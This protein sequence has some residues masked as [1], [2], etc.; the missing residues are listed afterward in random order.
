MKSADNYK[1]LL[2]DSL[3][4]LITILFSI[5][6]TSKASAYFFDAKEVIYENNTSGLAS[7]NVQDAIDELNNSLS[8]YDALDQKITNLQNTY[9]NKAHPVGSIYITTNYTTVNEV[10]A[11]FGG[12]WVVFGNGKTIK[13]S[14]GTSES[15]GGS[16]SVT[17]EIKNLPSHSHTIS[18]THT[19]PKTTIT[20]SGNH[21]H[22][23]TAKA[24]SNPIK[25][26]GTTIYWISN[27]KSG[28]IGSFKGG[29][30]N[31]ETISLTIPAL[32]IASSGAH[33]HDVPAMTTNSIS[34]TKSGKTGG[35]KSFSVENPY[36]TVHMFKRTA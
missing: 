4:I 15:T 32:S 6:I 5:I 29:T 26:S 2:N 27:W 10:A 9:L 30:A 14:T 20:S 25:V 34:T 1:S 22:T 31:S 23:T 19:T 28:S 11:A 13:S 16:N 8:N 18:H 35:G 12:T 24:V 7:T 33:T 17:L 36:I 3:V 21:T